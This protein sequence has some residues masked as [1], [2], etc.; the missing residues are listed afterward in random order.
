MKCVFNQTLLMKQYLVH[1]PTYFKWR[2][3]TRASE[4]ARTAIP[5]DENLAKHKQN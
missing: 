4:V 1:F 2:L 3:S 5:G